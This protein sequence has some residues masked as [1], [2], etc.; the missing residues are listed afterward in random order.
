MSTPYLPR[1]TDPNDPAASADDLLSLAFATLDRLDLDDGEVPENRPSEWWRQQFPDEVALLGALARNPKSPPELL[2]KIFFIVP[3]EVLRHAT[4]TDELRLIT[5]CDAEEMHAARDLNRF[6]LRA[7]RPWVRRILTEATSPQEGYQLL[8]RLPWLMKSR[9]QEVLRDWAA[10]RK[11]S[12]EDLALLAQSPDPLVRPKLANHRNLLPQTVEQLL[13]DEDEEVR[14][15]AAK[16]PSAS[17]E[18]IDLMARAE[19]SA[20]WGPPSERADYEPEEL[21][22]M[23]SA[24]EL[25]RLLHGGGHARSLALAHLED[26]QVERLFASGDASMRRAIAQARP[27]ETLMPAMARDPDPEIRK[28]AARSAKSSE[29]IQLLLRDPLAE[30]REETAGNWNLPPDELARFAEHPNRVVRF[31]VA[32]N[33]ST[34]RAVLERLAE[35]SAP[36]VR[37]KAL[38]RL[39]GQ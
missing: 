38:E 27:L 20:S 16:H 13:M 28:I 14:A 33:R 7:E 17:A 3:L 2:G 22:P 5:H 19:E 18:L 32:L 10:D 24:E 8:D 25:Q 36:R 15:K 35:D 23:L 30:V 39:A 21:P 12:G 26:D 4:L 34:P 29:L 1:V 37:E 11:T 9:I 6:L 31:T